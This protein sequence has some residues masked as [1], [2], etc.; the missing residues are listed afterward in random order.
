MSYTKLPF[1]QELNLRE[2][3]NSLYKVATSDVEK[4]KILY[5][6]SEKNLMI[7]DYWLNLIILIR[8]ITIDEETR[9]SCRILALSQFYSTLY[10]NQND[11]HIEW[12]GYYDIIEKCETYDTYVE[13]INELEISLTFPHH[14]LEIY[15]KSK[16]SL[17]MLNIYRRYI[18]FF[19]GDLKMIEEYRN[20]IERIGF[21]EDVT[22]FWIDTI[23]FE[24]DQSHRSL[25]ASSFGKNGEKEI[26]NFK[27]VIKKW[28][29]MVSKK[30][31][32]SDKIVEKIPPAP[33][34]VPSNPKIKFEPSTAQ[35]QSFSLQ[36]SYIYQ[37]LISA[38][39]QIL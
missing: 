30:Y 11:K 13:G 31:V 7:P 33:V 9:N 36:R 32:K 8:S 26:L 3:R 37:I 39:P 14:E 4:A 21:D 1:N 28:K 24:I 12:D 23:E 35:M 6:Y 2:I 20:E 5:Q 25:Y 19:I 16:N 34:S 29:E 15:M 22:D 10:G 18:R 38:N 17:A 27:N